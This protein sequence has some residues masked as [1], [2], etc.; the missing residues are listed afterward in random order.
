MYTGRT[1]TSAV[2]R[3]ERLNQLCIDGEGEKQP[4]RDLGQGG[5][6]QGEHP[7]RIQVEALT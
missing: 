3:E 1:D 2:Y 5:S 4:S 7:T 6:I